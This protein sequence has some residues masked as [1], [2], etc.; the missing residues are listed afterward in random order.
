[1]SEEQGAPLAAT[2]AAILQAEHV[3][4]SHVMLYSGL[5]R[6]T[7]GYILSGKTQR[8]KRKTLT[9][10]AGA[11][12]TDQYTRERDRQKA[13]EIE[14]KLAFGAGYADPAGREARS[15][16]ELALYY[17]LRSL[18]RARAWNERIDRHEGLTALRV[19]TLEPAPEP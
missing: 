1:M 15:L 5:S 19:R 6:N 11:I 17:R 2:L 3:S 7:I 4:I 16:L 18:E 12:A 8:P 9:L 14:R 13:A 10:I